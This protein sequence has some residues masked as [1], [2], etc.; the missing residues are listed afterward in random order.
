MNI[1]EPSFPSGISLARAKKD[2]KKLKKLEDITLT[3]ALNRVAQQHMSNPY[4]TW[5]QSI[6]ELKS[7]HAEV[8]D[9]FEDCLSK[10]ELEQFLSVIE[11]D[12]SAGDSF[13]SITPVNESYIESDGS[14]GA[15]WPDPLV[16][17]SDN[18]EYFCEMLNKMSFQDFQV[19]YL[20]Y[21]MEELVGIDL[22]DMWENSNY[23]TYDSHDFVEFDV[24]ED[25]D[26]D[27]LYDSYFELKRRVKIAID[28]CEK[29]A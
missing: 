20:G 16:V 3:Q 27:Q 9:L 6:T 5:E 19:L 10:S 14:G 11:Q 29:L 7:T 25:E 12:T 18:A 15:M 28:W 24:N 4:V 1:N 23:P 8:V 13:I 26:N 21:E 22:Y 17:S 2:A